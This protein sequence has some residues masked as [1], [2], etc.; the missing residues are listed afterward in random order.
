MYSLDGGSEK[1]AAAKGDA[2]RCSR[3]RG[4]AQRRGEP[5]ATNCCCKREDKD[6]ARERCIGDDEADAV[7]AAV[8]TAAVNDST[9][10]AAAI[11]TATRPV[12]LAPPSVVVIASGAGLLRRERYSNRG[13]ELAEEHAEAQAAPRPRAPAAAAA[14]DAAEFGIGLTWTGGLEG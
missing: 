14:N 6:N 8:A 1:Q 2:G 7:A 3:G 12:A 10:D 13:L 11:P 4:E 5:A 9:T